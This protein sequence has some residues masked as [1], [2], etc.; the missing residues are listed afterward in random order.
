MRKTE[1]NIWFCLFHLIPL[2][3]ILNLTLWS[4]QHWNNRN[5]RPKLDVFHHQS[6]QYLCYHL[7]ISL[8]CNQYLNNYCNNRDRMLGFAVS[9]A[10]PC[11][12]ATTPF[13]L[14]TVFISSHL[15]PLSVNL[16]VLPLPLTSVLGWVIFICTLP[17]VYTNTHSLIEYLLWYSWL[18]FPFTK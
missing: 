10:I 13:K 16:T 12:S 17:Y 3:G 11:F 18:L 8:L 7:V 4:K 5:P 6:N 9:C 14:G 2:N 15:L 1:W